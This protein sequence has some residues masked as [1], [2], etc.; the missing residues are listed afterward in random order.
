MTTDNDNVVPFP[1]RRTLEAELPSLWAWGDRAARYRYYPQ[2]CGDGPVEVADDGTVYITITTGQPS[3]WGEWQIKLERGHWGLLEC[4]GPSRQERLIGTF[5]T[6]RDALE[7]ICPT[8][9]VVA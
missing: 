3:N 5:R 9:M 8:D 6:L 7:T 1:P 4:D 2:D